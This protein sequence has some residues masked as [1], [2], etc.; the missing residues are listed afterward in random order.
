MPSAQRAWRPAGEATRAPASG[1][2]PLATTRVQVT[3]ALAKSPALSEA[4]SSRSF[5]RSRRFDTCGHLAC[6]AAPAG[7]S[8]LAATQPVPGSTPGRVEP[9]PGRG[10]RQPVEPALA[11]PQ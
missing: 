9:D 7:G 8:A 2:E 5:G 6:V 11:Q 1:C 10:A 3:G 4:R